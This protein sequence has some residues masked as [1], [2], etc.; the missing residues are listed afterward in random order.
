MPAKKLPKVTCADCYFMQ[1]SLCALGLGEPCSTFRPAE[2]NLKPPAQ[3][4]LLFYAPGEPE[5]IW[6]FPTAAERA[7]LHAAE[8]KRSRGK[9]TAAGR[10]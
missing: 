2:A 5:P 8:T 9:P 10:R 7:A 1:H 3:L 6:S 4:R